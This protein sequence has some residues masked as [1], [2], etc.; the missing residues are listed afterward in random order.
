MN[1]DSPMFIYTLNRQKLRKIGPQHLAQFGQH[2]H[3]DY[4]HSDTVTSDAVN[5]DL[6]VGVRNA[7][8][9]T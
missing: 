3:N 9:R 7:S 8:D 2:G 4:G 5:S 6:E 1:K